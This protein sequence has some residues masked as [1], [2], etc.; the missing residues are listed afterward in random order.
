MSL[1]DKMKAAGS[2]KANTVADSIFFNDKSKDQI[3]TRVPIINVALGGKL[4]GGL[5]SGLTV[6]AG[7]S[8]HFKSNL[9]L[10]MVQA[11]MKKFPDSV[12]LFYDS[13][14]G[15]TPEYLAAH[16]IDP[17]KV[18]H[19]PIEHVEQ[20]KF[21][22]VK[23]LEEVDRK[24][25]VVVFIDSV[26]NLASKKEVEDAHD[27]KSVADMSRSKALKSLFR[28]ITPNLTIKDIP[29][30]V[31]G[32]TYQTLEMFSKQVLSGGCMVAGTKV[33]M[34]DGSLR[35]IET[36]LPGESVRTLLGPKAVKH[37]WTPET[38]TEGEPQCYEIEFADGLKVVTSDKHRF[39][40]NKQW[41]E[42]Q[43]LKSGDDVDTADS[44]AV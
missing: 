14:F 6:I 43:N 1:L 30:I 39:L 4:D 36:I 18:I 26:G 8:K 20:L 40:V 9:G 31:V 15:V 37:A 16:G 12:C 23:R 27:E 41:V 7:P 13:E 32:H 29:C 19:I 38:L 42:A 10:I 21:D 17:N 24:D 11:Y 25:R 28:I 44:L 3:P 34:A 5:T 35:A 22:I 33:Q 2:I